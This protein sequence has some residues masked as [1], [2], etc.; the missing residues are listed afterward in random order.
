MLEDA[1]AGVEVGP[2]LEHVA[3]E[4]EAAGRTRGDRAQLRPDQLDVPGLGR[5]CD[6]PW[7]GHQIGERALRTKSRE[8]TVCG[9]RSCPATSPQAARGEADERDWSD[10][11]A[12]PRSD[13]VWLEWRP[14]ICAL[15][16]RPI[17]RSAPLQVK[18]KGISV[19]VA[20]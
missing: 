5:A 11:L 16:P 7:G 19:R 3:A 12:G 17:A 14:T 15:A 20:S 18:A 10:E 13:I 1:G 9:G 4:P 6:A 2:L 8:T